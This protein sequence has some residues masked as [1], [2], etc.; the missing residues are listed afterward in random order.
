MAGFFGTL[1]HFLLAMTGFFGT[2]HRFLLVVTG[3][4]TDLL[5][6]ERYN[7]VLISQIKR[8]EY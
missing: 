7:C 3:L 1:H 2:L 6:F 8:H 5:F 4:I